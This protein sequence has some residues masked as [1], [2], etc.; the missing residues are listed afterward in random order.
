[1]KKI[2][3]ATLYLLTCSLA[4][5]QSSLPFN[6]PTDQIAIQLG[7]IQMG[8]T[9]PFVVTTSSNSTVKQKAC[10][11]LAQGR[12]AMAAT[13]SAPGTNVQGAVNTPAVDTV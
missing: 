4:F 12:K 7:A 10:N 13:A 2:F 3:C 8:Y 5:A 9:T 6:H 11:A 1:M